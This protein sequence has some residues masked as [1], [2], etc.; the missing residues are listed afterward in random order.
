MRQNQAK[1]LVERALELAPQCSSNRVIQARLKAEGFS[2]REITAH[3]SGLD[4]RRRL[5][6]LRLAK[7]G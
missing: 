4:L 6:A 1:T 7:Q 2:H 3:F 5:K